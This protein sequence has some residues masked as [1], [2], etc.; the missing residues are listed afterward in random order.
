MALSSLEITNTSTIDEDARVRCAVLKRHV[1]PW[2]TAT[3]WVEA[4]GRATSRSWS[5]GGGR[6][7][8]PATA[9]LTAAAVRVLANHPQSPNEWTDDTSVVVTLQALDAGRLAPEGLRM[10]LDVSN[11]YVSQRVFELDANG[12][13]S[14]RVAGGNQDGSDCSL[15]HALCCGARYDGDRR[16]LLCFV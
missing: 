1:P 5:T 6:F 12:E 13:A 3:A 11:C 8:P 9:V 10:W 14:F 2:G 7:R 4:R 15:R 16:R